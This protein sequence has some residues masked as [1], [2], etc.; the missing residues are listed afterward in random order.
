MLSLYFVRTFYKDK[1]VPVD[2]KYLRN[3][4]SAISGVYRECGQEF[5]DTVLAAAVKAPEQ[6]VGGTEEFD[7]Y[8]LGRFRT[9]EST[10]DEDNR[11]KADGVLRNLGLLSSLSTKKEPKPPEANEPSTTKGTDAASAPPTVPTATPISKGE[12]PVVNNC[13]NGICISGGTVNGPTV[14]NNFGTPRPPPQVKWR[15]SDEKD[16]LDLFLV[17]IYLANQTC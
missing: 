9:G 5:T 12:P 11:R 6:P 10:G 17:T 14:N 13:P 4:T 2:S 7:S 15:L 3:W 8:F 1:P 16:T